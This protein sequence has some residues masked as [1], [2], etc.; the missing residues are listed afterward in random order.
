MAFLAA[1]QHGGRA[2]RVDRAHVMAD[3]QQGAALA[4]EPRQ[5]AHALLLEVGITHAQRLIDDEDVRIHVRDHRK[6]QADIH[7]AGVGLHR[8]FDEAADIGKCRDG[9]EALGHRLAIDAIQRS[10][11]VDVLAARKFR[12]EAGAELQ[13]RGDPAVD[14][15]LALGRGEG[16]ADHLQQG[17]FAGT[18]AADDADGLAAA[19]READ[20]AQCPEFAVVL[21]AATPEHLHQAMRRLFVDVETLAQVAHLD[22]DVRA[23]RQ[24]PCA[25]AGRRR[26]QRRTPVPK[27]AGRW[28][29]APGPGPCPR[30]GHHASARR[31]APAG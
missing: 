22:R 10:C 31:S 20:F 30:S 18:V 17:G 29:T 27:P 28:G 5:E 23:H 24:T 12:I 21:P 13:Q 11:Q 19:D 4:L 8:L 16:A 9:I 2:Q 7:A 26:S 3:E 1:Q 14:R 15:D 25:C 6:R